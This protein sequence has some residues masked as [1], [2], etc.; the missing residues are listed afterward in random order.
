M[1]LPLVNDHAKKLAEI[2]ASGKSDGE[3]TAEIS[4]ATNEALDEFLAI[5]AQNAPLI[6]AQALL[7]SFIDQLSRRAEMIRISNPDAAEALDLAVELA[8]RA[9]I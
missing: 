1:N 4:V 9:S 8:S 7:A 5:A 6:D 2:A 3:K